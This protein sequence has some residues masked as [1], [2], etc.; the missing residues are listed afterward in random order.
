MSVKKKKT[1]GNLVFQLKSRMGLGL[2]FKGE[3]V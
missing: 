3:Y 1:A 2:A